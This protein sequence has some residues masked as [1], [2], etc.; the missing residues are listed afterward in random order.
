MTGTQPI[1][2]RPPYKHKHGYNQLEYEDAAAYTYDRVVL[3]ADRV[4]GACRPGTDADD[5]DGR[6]VHP[7]DD[8][9]VGEYDAQ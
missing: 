2:I 7:E 8:V 3:A 1:D 9:Q 4:S 5:R 6:A